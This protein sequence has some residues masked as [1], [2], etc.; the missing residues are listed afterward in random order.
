MKKLLNPL[1]QWAM[2]D[3]D[4]RGVVVI[5]TDEEKSGCVLTG[6]CLNIEKAIAHAA[7]K[8]PELHR[9]LFVGLLAATKNNRFL[10]LRTRLI[11]WLLK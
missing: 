3:G 1:Q 4:N 5:A 10:S 7:R 6:T 8:N 9:V 2:E 11:A